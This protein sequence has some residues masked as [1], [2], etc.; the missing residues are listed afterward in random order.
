MPLTVGGGVR[1][2][3]GHPRAAAGRRRQGLDQHRRRARPRLRRA[4]LG[5]IR[6][7][8]HHGR[9]RRQGDRARRAT[10]SSRMAGAQPTGIDA[11]AF[12]RADGGARRGRDPADLDGPRRH[13]RGLRPRPDARRLRAPSACPVIASGGVGTLDHLVEGV[14]EGGASAVLAASIFH[15]GQHSIAEAKAHMAARRHPGAAMSASATCC[16]GSPRPSRRGA[17]PT[18]PARTRRS[19]WP[20]GRRNAPQKFGEEAVEAVIEAA[21][22]DREALV[23]RRRRRALPSP[24]HAGGA[25]RDARR[26][27]GRARAARG[28]SGIAEKA[29]RRRE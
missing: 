2:H 9:H 29:A 5:E 12:A 23:A 10:R 18:R 17:A 19:C 13:A 27:A 7:A 16:S 8:V 3:R 14:T 24:G 26:R 21:R 25:R 1:T 6:R 4:R 15:F 22:G 20:R 11:V 28:L